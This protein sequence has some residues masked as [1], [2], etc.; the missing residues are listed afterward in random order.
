MRRAR[1]KRKRREKGKERKEE[2]RKK[3][4]INT[5]N[6]KMKQKR[7][8]RKEEREKKTRKMC[9]KKRMAWEREGGGRREQEEARGRLTRRI[10]LAILANV[11][12]SGYLD[13]ASFPLP[14]AYPLPPSVVLLLSS[15]TLHPISSTSLSQLS[16]HPLPHSSTFLFPL[17][18]LHPLI[19]LLSPPFH[20]SSLLLSSTSPSSLLHFLFTLSLRPLCPPS[21]F[22]FTQ[23]CHPSVPGLR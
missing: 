23:L 2:K 5:T 20:F 17:I 11:C 18:T 6:N 15:L 14:R 13:V 10:R 3:T 9:R 22:F 19:L 16:F 4:N 8:E 21:P 7:K 1:K 12:D